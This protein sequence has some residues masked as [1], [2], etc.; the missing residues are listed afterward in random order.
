MIEDEN[1]LRYSIELIA[2]MYSSQD[3]EAGEPV[4]SP[5]IREQMADDTKHMRLKIEREV[6]EYLAARYGYTRQPVELPA[7]PPMRIEQAA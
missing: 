1:Q 4:W 2:R 5:E 7:A 6:A 3:R